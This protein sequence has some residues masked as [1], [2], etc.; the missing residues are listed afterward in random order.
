MVA[1]VFVQGSNIEGPTRTKVTLDPAEDG[2]C[3]VPEAARLLGI[4]E[5]Q[6]RGRIR[7]HAVEVQRDER[8]RILVNTRF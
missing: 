8:N 6:L 2:W 7:R 5:S 4:T 3:L 1:V